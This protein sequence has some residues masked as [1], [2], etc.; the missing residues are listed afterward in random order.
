MNEATKG[1]AASPQDVQS[2]TRGGPTAAQQAEGAR[3]PASDN[4]ALIQAALEQAR[5]FD[6]NGQEA[7]CTDAVE[8][9][10]RLLR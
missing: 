5:G 1:G 3:R 9:A 8:Q 4:L 6:R 10:K 7:Q 2:Q